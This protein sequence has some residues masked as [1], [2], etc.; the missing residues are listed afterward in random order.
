MKIRQLN[1]WNNSGKVYVHIK[2][3]TDLEGKKYFS[4]TFASMNRLERVLNDW[5]WKNGGHIRTTL[6]T[7]FTGLH[8]Y[9]NY[10]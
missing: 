10:K 8:C 2:R 6:G 9:P 5:H 1:I 3:G 7:T 4:P